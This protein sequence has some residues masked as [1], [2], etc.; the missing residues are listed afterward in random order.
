MWGDAVTASEDGELVAPLMGVPEPD[1]G[2]TIFYVGPLNHF[3]A[4]AD[5]GAIF[6]YVPRSVS[7]TEL[8]VTWLVRGDA[9]EGVDFDVDRLTWL[10]RVTVAADQQIIEQNRARGGVAALPARSVRDADRGDH[11]PSHRLVHR[12]P[13][14]VIPR[15]TPDT[16]EVLSHGRPDV[17]GSE[18]THRR[19]GPGAGRS[20]TGS[21]PA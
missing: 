7:H 19:P 2:F 11:R 14:R 5:Y 15:M 21:G 9:V 16:S 1:G 12:R 6:R 3:L 13:R 20:S 17:T 8:V 10:W 18:A 4:Y